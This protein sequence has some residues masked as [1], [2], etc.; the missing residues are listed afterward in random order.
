MIRR[1]GLLQIDFV[2]VLVPAHYQPIFSRLGP[3]SIS[4]FDKVVYRSREFTEQWPHEACIIPVETWPLLRFRMKEHR[5][6]PRGFESF[7]KG[8]REYAQGVLDLV[9]D[10]G[11]LAAIDVPA[12]DGHGRRLDQ[13]W[14][15]TIPRAV[16]EAHFGRG[17]LTV[18]ARRPDMARVFDLPERW[19]PS[20]HYD[21]EVSRE[22]AHRELLERASRA[23]G[24]ATLSDLADYY[25]LS[26]VVCRPRVEELVRWGKLR[27]IEVEGWREPAFL[28]E[29]ASAPRL[30][31]SAALLSP[32]DPLIFYR[33]RVDRLFG[34]HYRL[35]IYTPES[36]R[37]YGYYVL[38]FLQGDRLVA[39]VDLK[40][41]RTDSTLLVRAS[42]VES[43]ADP[44]EVAQ[45]LADELNAW[46]NWLGLRHLAIEYRGNLAKAL[47]KA[48]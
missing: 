36:Q 1:L 37:K 3:Y 26:P 24:V 25:R 8:N 41:S 42:H 45:S 2:N 4:A 15:G 5:L 33:P 7:L 11:P 20:E 9:R 29:E 30:T 22:E 35:E 43:E 27:K 10:R 21:R 39:R 40:A 44:A 19:I 6:R 14:F 38:P 48:C 28:H 16:L 23:L 12:P 31:V 13:S 32:F 34:F 18:T 47:A 46:A 17:A